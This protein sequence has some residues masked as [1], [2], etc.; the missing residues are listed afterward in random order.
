MSRVINP[1]SLLIRLSTTS[2]GQADDKSNTI[3][4]DMDYLSPP[5]LAIPKTPK[6]KK[7]IAPTPIPLRSIR[8]SERRS[9]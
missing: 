9:L 1:T 8:E 6:P 4:F 7:K 5:A 2:L 3:V